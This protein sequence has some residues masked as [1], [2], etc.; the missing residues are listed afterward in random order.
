MTERPGAEPRPGSSTSSGRALVFI[1]FRSPDGDNS[2]IEDGYRRMREGLVGKPGLVN[3]ELIHSVSDEASFG[4]LSEW[5]N[6]QSFAAWQRESSHGNDTEPMDSYLDH[7]RPG[8][9]YAE[10]FQIIDAG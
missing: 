10:V 9:R 8:G 4:V 5:E 1:W 3:S 7:T 6:A 2:G